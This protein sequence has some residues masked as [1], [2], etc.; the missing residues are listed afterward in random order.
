MIE[1]YFVISNAC[2]KSKKRLFRFLNRPDSY[3]D[4]FRNDIIDK[5]LTLEQQSSL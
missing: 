4:S 1:N 5:V 2:E 3:R